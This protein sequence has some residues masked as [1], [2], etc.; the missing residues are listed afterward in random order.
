MGFCPLI[1]DEC[2]GDECIFGRRELG[3][4]WL[5][6]IEGFPVL[7]NAIDSLSDN[8]RRV[9]NPVITVNNGDGIELGERGRMHLADKERQQRWE[10]FM[11]QVPKADDHEI[12]Y[13]AKNQ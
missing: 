3:C 9:V 2:K 4:G 7:I 12:V 5:E 10:G 11:A 1:K 8:L 6:I 13:E